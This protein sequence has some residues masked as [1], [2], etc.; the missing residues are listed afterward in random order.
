[1]RTYSMKGPGGGQMEAV[2]PSLAKARSNLRAGEGVCW[3]VR[4]RGY[5]M[6][7]SR[8]PWG[9]VAA[10]PLLACAVTSRDGGV[11]GA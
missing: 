2:A 4:R 11:G 7:T 6:R 5:A 9:V 10:I 3:S 1:M 8:V